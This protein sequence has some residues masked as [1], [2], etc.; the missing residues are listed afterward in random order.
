MKKEWKRKPHAS[1][2]GGTCPPRAEG[3]TH[4]VTSSVSP[5]TFRESLTIEADENLVDMIEAFGERRRGT[6][7]EAYWDEFSDLM[8]QLY[9]QLQAIRESQIV[10]TF[11]CILCD[12]KFEDAIP[13][14]IS[15]DMF[16]GI[17][18]PECGN[19]NPH[20]VS[21]KGGA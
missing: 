21:S 15:A 14:A 2:S 4:E 12:L 8:R 7:V 17:K 20:V 3:E 19:N 16:S 10:L 18:C 11:R 6:T 13:S 9:Q 5:R 1:E